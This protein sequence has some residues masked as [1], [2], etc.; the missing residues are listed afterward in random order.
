MILQRIEK[1]IAGREYLIE[2][3]QVAEN[4]WRA[5]IV[6]IP[7]V[8]IAMMPFYGET[9]EEAATLL[10]NWLTRAHRHAATAI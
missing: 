5:Q 9:A 1:L 7:G 10:T 8:P 6:R 3:S 2:V 4:R